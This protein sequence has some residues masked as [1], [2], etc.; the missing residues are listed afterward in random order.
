MSI[1][2]CPYCG[3]TTPEIMHAFEELKTNAVND[4]SIVRQMS[5]INDTELNRLR[6]DVGFWIDQVGR[7]QA[8][9]IALEK[10][11]ILEQTRLNWLDQNCSFVADESYIIGPYKVGELRKLADDGIEIDNGYTI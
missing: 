6:R 7:E 5:S 8:K 3:S 4:V 2:K 9:V 10:E 1:A 11:L